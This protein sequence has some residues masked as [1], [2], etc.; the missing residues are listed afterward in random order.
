MD[1][2]FFNAVNSQPGHSLLTPRHS[3]IKEMDEDSLWLNG[4][5]YGKMHQVERQ[6]VKA[7]LVQLFVNH[8]KTTKDRE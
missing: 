4:V 1:G 6:K 5:G 3:Y 8:N 2:N 7:V